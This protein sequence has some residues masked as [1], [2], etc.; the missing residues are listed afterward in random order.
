MFVRQL[1]VTNNTTG[2]IAGPVSVWLGDLSDNAT[3]ANASGAANYIVLR[4][5][6]AGMAA[7]SSASATLQFLNPTNA[8]IYYTP[9]VQAAAQIP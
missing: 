8:A 3:L 6:G 4:G 7:G 2:A 9:H 5:T 1:T